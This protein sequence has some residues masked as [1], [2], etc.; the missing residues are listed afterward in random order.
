MVISVEQR[1]KQFEVFLKRVE[2]GLTSWASVQNQ[3]FLRQT[4]LAQNSLEQKYNQYFC[5]FFFCN[6]IRRIK[7]VC[8]IIQPGSNICGILL[9]IVSNTKRET[10][11]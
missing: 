7:V 4:G 11:S 6:S 9:C 2:M 5:W 1:L 3:T 8:D 10:T